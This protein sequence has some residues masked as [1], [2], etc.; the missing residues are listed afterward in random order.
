MA[1]PLEIKARARALYIEGGMTYDDVAAETGVSLSQLKE[2]GTSGEWF[3]ART[4]Y[5]RS[6][7]ELH[8]NVQ[9]V[10]LELSQKALQTK[11]PQLIYALSNL[12]RATAPTGG[13]GAT[14]DKPALFI[15]FAA[16]FVE[17]LKARDPEALRHLEPHLRGFAESVKEA[18]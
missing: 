6:F 3:A 18:A 9:R 2:W 15:G 14:P 8:A 5:E 7:L 1:Y 11:D 13:K 4:E 17:Y 10:K 16:Q 12:M